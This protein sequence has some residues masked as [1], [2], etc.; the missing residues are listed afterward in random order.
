[1]IDLLIGFLTAPLA[2]IGGMLG[3][4]VAYLAWT[5]LPETADRASIG[6]I[7]VVGGFIGGFA[8]ELLLSRKRPK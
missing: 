4:G 5:F 6:A 8:I 7:F 2:W 3:V 1:M